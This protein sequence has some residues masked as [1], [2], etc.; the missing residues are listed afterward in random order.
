MKLI[1]MTDYL[2]ENPYSKFLKQP[3]ELWMFVPC[4]DNG[5]VLKEPIIN[6]SIKIW[7]YQQA[8]ERCLFE[9]F[10]NIEKIAIKFKTIEDV[11]FLHP[12]LTKTA[13]KHLGL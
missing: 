4:D 5:N 12:T 8:K 11:I 6:D 1:S 2:P 7:T 9:G 3:L 10:E 13:I